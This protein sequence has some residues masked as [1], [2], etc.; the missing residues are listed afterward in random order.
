MKM[1]N[2]S[3][4]LLIEVLLFMEINFENDRD[5][6]YIPPINLTGQKFKKNCAVRITIILNNK[7][8]KIPIFNAFF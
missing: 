6:K 7:A 3:I 5:I 8:I 2:L 1:K 4:S